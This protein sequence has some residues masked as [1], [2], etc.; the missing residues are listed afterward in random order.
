MPYPDLKAL[1]ARAH[2]LHPALT[3]GEAGVS[4]GVLDELDR[5][6]AAQELVKVRFSTKDRKQRKQELKDLVLASEGELIL[7]IGK[8]ASIHRAGPARRPANAPEAAPV[9]SPPT[10]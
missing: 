5:M 6:L 7:A 8:V 10:A 3:V 9:P 2:E 4:D 1:R